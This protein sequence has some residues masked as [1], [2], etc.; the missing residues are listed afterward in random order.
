M[1]AAV[2]M[3]LGSCGTTPETLALPIGPDG[4]AAMSTDSP[5]VESTDVATPSIPPAAPAGESE[6]SDRRGVAELHA[7]VHVRPKL[8]RNNAVNHWRLIAPL[9]RCWPVSDCSVSVSLVESWISR[10][11]DN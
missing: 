1:F 8:R 2:L 10:M 3:C 5:G 9:Y 7:T 11:D 6:A 4:S